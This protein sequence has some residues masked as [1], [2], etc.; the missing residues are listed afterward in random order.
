[1]A[2]CGCAEVV[3][4][5]GSHSGFV[6][7]FD[8]ERILYCIY[9]N[10]CHSHLGRAGDSIVIRLYGGKLYV[11]DRTELLGGHWKLKQIQTQSSYNMKLN[12]VVIRDMT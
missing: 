6:G 12:V 4:L 10:M 7:D 9:I 3:G 2:G 1:M 8:L 11:G 5:W